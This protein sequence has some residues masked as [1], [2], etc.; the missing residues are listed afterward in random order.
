MPS[1]RVRRWKAATASASVIATYSAR[2]LAC[3]FGSA[4]LQQILS[5]QTTQRKRQSCAHIASVR[6]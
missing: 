5:E 4:R 1:V 2:P 6:A 3:R